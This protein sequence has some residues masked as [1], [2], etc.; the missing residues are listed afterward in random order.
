MANPPLV[1]PTHKPIQQYYDALQTYAGKNV[2]HEG[3]LETAFSR[4]LNDTAKV[5][6][7]TLVPKLPSKVGGKTIIPD[8]T[9][10]DD[11]NL[12]RGYWEAKDTHDDLDDEIRK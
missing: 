7:W 1:K 8:G 12:R 4:L 2:E 9:L 10:Q 5:K 11:F 3:A 6:V